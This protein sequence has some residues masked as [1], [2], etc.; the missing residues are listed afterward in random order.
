M[1]STK[2]ALLGCPVSLCPTSTRTPY[3]P[4]WWN[5]ELAISTLPQLLLQLWAGGKGPDQGWPMASAYC[6]TLLPLS[7][8]CRNRAASVPWPF[9]FCFVAGYIRTRSP[10]WSLRPL[11]MKGTMP[12]HLLEYPCG[13]CQNACASLGPLPLELRPI[14]DSNCPLKLLGL[15]IIIRDQ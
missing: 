8:P 4:L 15:L 1:G 5:L 2:M 7:P 11:C 10:L 14:Q 3:K 13:R 12:S 6:L 9:R